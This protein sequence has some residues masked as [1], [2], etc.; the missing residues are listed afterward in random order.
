MDMKFP[1][2]LIPKKI[3]FLQYS[4]PLI[5]YEGHRSHYE[6]I[7]TKG[8]FHSIKLLALLFRVNF[9]LIISQVSYHPILINN[10]W[11]H[12]LKQRGSNLGFA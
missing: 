4:S 9:P 8:H 10:F 2:P 11:E 1:L 6:F 12:G 7:I 3:C 5:A